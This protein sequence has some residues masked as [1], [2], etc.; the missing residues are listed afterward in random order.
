[1]DKEEE[2]KLLENAGTRT[3]EDSGSMRTT[4]IKGVLF[5]S[6]SVFMAALSGI[7]VQGL[8]GEIPDFELNTLRCTFAFLCFS[9]FSC[10]YKLNPVLRGKEV[11]WVTIYAILGTTSTLTY[12]ISVTWISMASEEA[13]Y[14]TSQML[15]G[16]ILLWTI[17]GEKPSVQNI[18]SV[19][20]CLLGV[21]LIFQP[22]FIFS[23]ILLSSNFSPR[24]MELCTNDLDTANETF[25]A[26]HLSGRKSFSLVG[27]ILAF[28]TGILMVFRLITI[29]WR[30][31][32]FGSVEKQPIIILWVSL[33]GAV[34]SCAVMFSVETLAFPGSLK[35]CVLVIIHSTSYSLT[36]PGFLYGSS[37]LS[38]N[39][40]N[41]LQSMNTIYMVAAQY[42]FL[43][44]IHP[45]KRNWIEV[46]GVGFI[47][48]G[49]VLSSL[50]DIVKKKRRQTEK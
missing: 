11:A 4:T 26:S 28:A 7:C 24:D 38:G 20:L 48:F 13:V 8:D 33:S 5:L 50:V 6:V 30:P 2:N 23:K 31:E 17:I 18:A 9:V 19:V 32:L 25:C 35:D 14:H 10:F 43:R 42:T 36:Y 46:T 16:M 41:I 49:C 21:L 1:M 40:V 3:A 37:A 39:T 12:Y 34:L 27:Y 47:I 22:P 29:K 15:G 45:G 44:N